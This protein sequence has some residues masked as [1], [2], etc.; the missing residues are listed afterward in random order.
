M[1]KRS[2][3]K[4]SKAKKSRNPDGTTHFQPT[5]DEQRGTDLVMVDGMCI[6]ESLISRGVSGASLV[7]GLSFV[8]GYAIP[9][10]EVDLVV[11]DAVQESRRRHREGRASGPIVFGR[12]YPGRGALQ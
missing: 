5:M 12:S 7:R 6:F 11:N 4:R 2:K 9:E 3:A 1:A 10:S 8:L